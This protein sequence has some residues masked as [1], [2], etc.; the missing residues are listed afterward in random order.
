MFLPP[1]CINMSKNANIGLQITP[2]IFFLSAQVFNRT[3]ERRVVYFMTIAFFLVNLEAFE[4]IKQ[5]LPN[6]S[7]LLRYASIS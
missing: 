2:Q 5:K 3:G 7:R 4:M 1:P 6:A